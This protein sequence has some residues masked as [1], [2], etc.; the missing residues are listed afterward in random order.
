MNGERPVP[1]QQGPRQRAPSFTAFGLAAEAEKLNPGLHLVATPIGNLKDISFRALAT[2]AAANAILAEDTRVTKT[3]LAH[4]GIS[5]PLVP[6]HEHNAAQMRPQILAR[7]KAGEALAL[8]SDAGTPL[9]SDPGFKLVASVLEEGIAVTSVP[10]AS[11]VLTALVVSGLPSDRFFFEG[12]LPQKSAGRRSRFAALAAVPG[13]LV[14]FESPRRLAA[15]LTDA[16]HV[17]GDRPAAVA[18]ELTK[19]FET[20][21]RGTLT[22]LAREYEA[23]GPPKGEIV[24]IIGPPDA[25]GEKGAAGDLDARI[26]A[27]LKIH[28]LKDAAAVVAADTGLPKREVYARALTLAA[29]AKNAPESN[30]GTEVETGDA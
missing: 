28:S 18:R 1:Q 21:R 24:V 20:V 11:A 26:E 25:D 9:V 15:M 27:A 16:A 8:V 17:L 4:Y 14:F 2:L 3:L 7:L 5:T 13:S 23:E 12:F 10:G 30:A 29:S 19:L 6:Y 22:S